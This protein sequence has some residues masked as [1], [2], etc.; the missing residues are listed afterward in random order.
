MYLQ[1]PCWRSTMVWSCLT[2]AAS[3]LTSASN[4]S[5]SHPVD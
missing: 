5:S 1:A 2:T 4:S 3:P